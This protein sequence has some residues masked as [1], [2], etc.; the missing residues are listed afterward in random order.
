[1]TKSRIDEATQ[2]IPDTTGLKAD[3]IEAAIAALEKKRDDLL[4]EKA[5]IAAGDTATADIRQRIA[6]AKTKLA[7]GRAEHTKAQNNKNSDIDTEI[8]LA[9]REASSARREA[10]DAE[11]DIGNRGNMNT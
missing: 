3:E 10:E 11:I 8:I 1:M 4:A 5:S 9:N 6:D 2:A 7:E